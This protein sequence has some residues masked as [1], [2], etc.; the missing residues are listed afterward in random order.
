MLKHFKRVIL[1]I[2]WNSLTYQLK[3]KTM[4]HNKTQILPK[5]QVFVVYNVFNYSVAVKVLLP[6]VPSVMNHG[7]W[8]S[9]SESCKR[10]NSNNPK[11]TTLTNPG[12]R[13]S[14]KA[15]CFLDAFLF[16]VF[17]LFKRIKWIYEWIVFCTLFMQ[18][19]NSILFIYWHWWLT[20]TIFILP[21]KNCV[22]MCFTFSYA[23][24]C[25]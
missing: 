10:D 12:L 24:Q 3:W 4:Y 11:K 14:K 20:F 22:C 8:K 6:V 7:N 13:L 5:F 21:K 16:F 2:Y 9:W 17:I 15:Y 23:Y 25:F 18:F 1:K 19:F